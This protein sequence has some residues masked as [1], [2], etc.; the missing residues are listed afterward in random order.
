MYNVN[1]TLGRKLLPDLT[2]RNEVDQLPIL[3]TGYDVEKL[4][5]V[6]KLD[7][8]TGEQMCYATEQALKD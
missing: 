4:L 8:G 1:C 7:R 6:P 5:S 3:V 2:S